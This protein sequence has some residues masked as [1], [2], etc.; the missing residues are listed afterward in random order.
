VRHDD[1][2]STSTQG[3]DVP[4]FGF[5]LD[6]WMRQMQ[7]GGMSEEQIKRVIKGAFKGGKGGKGFGGFDKRGKGGKGF[8]GFGF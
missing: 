6:G 4:D 1:S 5:D 7:N 3:A 8:G 2:F